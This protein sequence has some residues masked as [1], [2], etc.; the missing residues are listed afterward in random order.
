MVRLVQQFVSCCRAAGLRI[1]TSE[2]LDGLG[3]LRLINP[4]DELQFRALLAANFAKSLRDLQHFNRLSIFFSRNARDMGDIAKAETWNR[5]I[6]DAAQALK[7]K[8][9]DTRCTTPSWIYGRIH[10]PLL[11][12]NAR[13]TRNRTISVGPRFNFGPFASAFRVSCNPARRAWRGC[14]DKFFHVSPQTLNELSDPSP[15]GGRG[16][17]LLMYERTGDQVTRKITTQEQRFRIW[18]KNPSRP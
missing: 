13:F 17:L 6:Q 3:Q 5:Q 12:E 4:I 16:A 14:L 15:S 7:E 11:A 18:A 8:P 9:H 10:M 1:S 2:V